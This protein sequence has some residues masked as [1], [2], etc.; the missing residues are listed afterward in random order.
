MCVP[1]VEGVLLCR[2]EQRLTRPTLV[3]RLGPAFRDEHRCHR[4]PDWIW[5]GRP[6]NIIIKIQAGNPTVYRGE[7]RDTAR[8]NRRSMADRLPTPNVTYMNVRNYI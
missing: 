6:L 8:N 5:C 2:V 7:E 1:A 4:R 3:G